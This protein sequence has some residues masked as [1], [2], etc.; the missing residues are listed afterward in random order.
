MKCFGSATSFVSVLCTYGYSYTIFLPIVIVCS[1]P[2]DLMQWVLIAYA[3]FSSTSFIVVN[4]WIELS[5]YMQKR[6]IIVI[7][8]ILVCQVGLFLIMKLY[9][10]QKFT[11]AMGV[12]I[13]LPGDSPVPTT[14]S[15][16][17]TNHNNTNSN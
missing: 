17:I 11:E 13:I 7:A 6:K 4:Y 9:F 8:F 2:I 14:N 15:T 10:F 16:D 3:V 1:I 5:K 12:N